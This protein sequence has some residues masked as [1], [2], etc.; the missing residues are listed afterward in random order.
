M[1]L[2]SPKANR[3]KLRIKIK[4]HK[5]II[6]LEFVSVGKYLNMNVLQNYWFVPKSLKTQKS[7]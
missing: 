3:M 2:D 1:N 4:V 5:R 6:V 7:Q